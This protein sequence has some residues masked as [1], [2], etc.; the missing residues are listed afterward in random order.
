MA[1][2]LNKAYVVLATGQLSTIVWHCTRAYRS[3]LDV[4]AQRYCDPVALLHTYV[5]QSSSQSIRV[6]IECIV[7][8][9]SPLVVRYDP[10]CDVSRRHRG[11]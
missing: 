11:I 6:A 2:S 1:P 7:R 4:V 5:L 8:K 3:K 9:D 10:E